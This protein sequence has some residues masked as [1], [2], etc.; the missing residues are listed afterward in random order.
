MKDKI[1]RAILFI[2]SMIGLCSCNSLGKISIQVA[3]PPKNPVSPDI[4]SIAI[5]NRSI[6]AKSVN[7]QY[8]WVENI[9]ER[10][11]LNFERKYSDSVAM[12]TLINV[13]ARSIYELQRFD[14]IVPVQRIIPRN[15][16]E[17][18]AA[19]LDSSFIDEL[20]KD[21]N[22]DGILVLEAFYEDVNRIVKVL[23]SGSRAVYTG[24]LDLTY[25]STWRFYQPKQMPNILNYYAIDDIYWKSPGYYNSRGEMDQKL[26][27]LRDA[28]NGGALAAGLDLAKQLCPDW[29][30]ESR[31]Y[32]I[33][34]NKKIDAAIPLIKLNQWDEA[35]EIWK[36]HS[37][38]SSNSLRSKIEY[39]LALASEMKG[40]IEGANEWGGKSLK[41]KYSR[42]AED[43]LMNLSRRPLN[44]SRYYYIT[45]NPEID[46]AVPLIQQHK[47]DEASQIWM[48]HYSANDKTLQ[49]KIEYN[50]AL[51]E[52]MKGNID[53][54]IR[55]GAKSLNTYNSLNTKQYLNE[56]KQIS[57][58][59][60]V[61]KNS[62][63]S[64]SR[65]SWDSESSIIPWTPGREE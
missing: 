57:R 29:K 7:L 55:W 53:L 36:N 31:F 63:R 64:L 54:A 4:Q 11:K 48:K 43:Y 47:W 42:N 59:N 2:I 6:T 1:I 21:F 51:T 26:P 50:L 22:V 38:E 14:V 13:L 56:L 49:S 23:P 20:C 52:E 45:G 17:G 35:F 60:K 10:N 41:S 19:P 46:V 16:L 8:D 9:P 30:D 32:Y 27:T 25:N 65:N 44:P 3:V 18:E 40:D 58:L 61:V 39:N 12:D 33:T 24:T 62:N 37:S 5:F 28:L 15:D 34:G